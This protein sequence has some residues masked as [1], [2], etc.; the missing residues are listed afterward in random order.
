MV[1][2]LFTGLPERLREVSAPVAGL[3]IGLQRMSISRMER[4]AFL[5]SVIHIS[6]SQAE[7]RYSPTSMHEKLLI[8]ESTGIRRVNLAL[9]RF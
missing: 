4:K 7:H 3:A 9:D 1:M 5:Y 2:A 8:S 6:C